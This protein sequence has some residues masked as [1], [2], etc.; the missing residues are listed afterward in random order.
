MHSLHKSQMQSIL[1]C[2][3]PATTQVKQCELSEYIF[4]KAGKCLMQ[5]ENST[6]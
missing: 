5:L 2:R 6:I 1:S 3:F 4:R